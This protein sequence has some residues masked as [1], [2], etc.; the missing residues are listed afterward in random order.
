MSRFVNVDDI[1]P[2][3]WADLFAHDE[4]HV[5]RLRD[6]IAARGI[7]TPLHVYPRG[8]RYELLTGHDRFEAVRRLELDDVP[9]EVRTTLT[10]EADRFAYFVKDNTLRKPVDKQAISRAVLRLHPD[11]SNRRIAQVVG[12]SEGTVRIAR[13]DG[14]AGGDVRNVTQ[15]EDARGHLR[16]A[17]MP[18]RPNVSSVPDLAA[19]RQR[20]KAQEGSPEGVVMSMKEVVT[21]LKND[22]NAHRL[23]ARQHRQHGS[24]DPPP[25]ETQGFVEEGATLSE[26]EE[27][28]EEIRQKHALIESLSKSD[29]AREIRTLR[30]SLETLNA[31]H[32]QLVKAQSETA[33]ERNYLRDLVADIRSELGVKKNAEILD[34]IRA[35]GAA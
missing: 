5:E 35:R 3:P 6:D 31:R 2:S 10:D 25:P 14:E 27:A 19:Y 29:H 20:C 26:L 23:Y 22:A 30:H 9:V 21:T 17:K 28:H 4:E 7:L 13:E 16:P 24:E 32:Q 1:D 18:E 33:S 12:C 11:W 15:I 8:G 34:A